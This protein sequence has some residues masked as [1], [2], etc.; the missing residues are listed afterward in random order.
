[1]LEHQ[2]YDKSF[3]Q[4]Q[5]LSVCGNVPEKSFPILIFTVVVVVALGVVLLFCK[6]FCYGVNSER[7]KAYV[8]LTP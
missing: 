5:Y 6:R 7:F 8:E 3:I 4:A 2:D 1:M